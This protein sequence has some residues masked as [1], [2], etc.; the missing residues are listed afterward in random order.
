[1]TEDGDGVRDWRRGLC[2]RRFIR[3]GS[4]TWEGK[5]VTDGG[6]EPCGR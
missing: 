5:A 6:V 1:M 3:S 4:V 2:F